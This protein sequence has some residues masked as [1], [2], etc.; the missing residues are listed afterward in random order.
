MSENNGGRRPGD[1]E[2]DQTRQ[3][4]P[5]NE[6]SPSQAGSEPW[7]GDQQSTQSFQNTQAYQQP[8][9]Q[10]GQP[11]PYGQD[12]QPYPYGQG[13]YPGGEGYGAQ[14]YGEQQGYGQPQYGQQGYGHEGYAQGGQPGGYPPAYGGGYDGSGG[15]PPYGGGYGQP[16]QKGKGPLI[17]WIVLGVLLLAAIIVGILFGTGVLGGEDEPETTPTTR[18]TLTISP[19]D[20]PTT[21][22]PG[23]TVSPTTPTPPSGD[24]Q[25]YGDDPELDALWDSCEA[26]NMADCDDLYFS[27][28]IGTDY[29]EFGN[30]CGNTTENSYGLCEYDISLG[31]S[32]GAYG[33][34]PEMDALW[35]SCE[36]GDMADCDELWW[37]S[38]IGSEY[39]MF[40]E[41]CGG[42]TQ[43]ASGTCELLESTGGF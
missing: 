33:D 43:D 12:G 2:P 24:P 36:A 15:Y 25:S 28:S 9:G 27:S 1:E 42:R 18:E 37:N 34:D 22:T 26:G 30:T 8:Y 4:Q 16:P 3:F 23:P 13:G 7:S 17:A 31:T 41:S 20:D 14:Q 40:A 35:D 38:S 5:Q 29:E 11:Y 19:T 6:S 39:E 21:P 32:G 10:G